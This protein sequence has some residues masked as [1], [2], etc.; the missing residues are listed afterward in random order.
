MPF[1]IHFPRLFGIR[2]TVH[3]G[4]SVSSLE[5]TN[6]SDRSREVRKIIDSNRLKSAG[7]SRGK[8]IVPWRVVLFLPMLSITYH[9][10]CHELVLFSCLS[11]GLL[12]ILAKKPR[13]KILPYIFRLFDPSING[14]NSMTPPFCSK[15]SPQAGP[16]AS[17]LH[18]FH[19]MW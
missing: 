13:P 3:P 11:L 6:I 7:D 16:K 5:G 1:F 19:C 4:G 14:Y 12:R 18:G 15:I 10:R 9:A 17:G 8:V 2:S